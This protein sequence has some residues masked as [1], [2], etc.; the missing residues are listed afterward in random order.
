M[1]VRAI[2]IRNGPRPALAAAAAARERRRLPR[3][4]FWAW[5]ADD[6]QL[7]G[8]K[9]ILIGLLVLAGM[10]LEVPR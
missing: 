7:I 3:A 6:R 8:V 2:A 4:T 1:S 5:F 10:A 9:L